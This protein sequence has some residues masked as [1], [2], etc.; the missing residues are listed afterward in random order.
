MFK[1][2]ICLYLILSMNLV[3]TDEIDEQE[4]IEPHS[5]RI[6]ESSSITSILVR[7]LHRRYGNPDFNEI[8]RN[9]E[10]NPTIS[11]DPIVRVIREETVL[12]TSSNGESAFFMQRRTPLTV[13][14]KSRLIH[15]QN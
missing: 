4:N 5:T 12:T 10:I 2:F 7:N 9:I 6:P 3:S 8:P 14:S 11:Q 1:F 13:K 15:E